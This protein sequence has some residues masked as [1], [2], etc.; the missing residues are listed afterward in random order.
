MRNVR[1]FGGFASQ[2]KSM[3]LKV[4]EYCFVK[5]SITDRT[6]QNVAIKSHHR[7]T[8]CCLLSFVCTSCVQMMLQR[9]FSMERAGHL[10]INTHNHTCKDRHVRYFTQVTYVDRYDVDSLHSYFALPLALPPVGKT[11]RH[12]R[13]NLCALGL[14]FSRT[15]SKNFFIAQIKCLLRPSILL[16]LCLISRNSEN[17]VIMIF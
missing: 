14:T 1:N 15:T 9:I 11:W 10:S 6:G 17:R 2:H 12:S 3:Q 4:P 16:M 7:S 8:K 13:V 5:P